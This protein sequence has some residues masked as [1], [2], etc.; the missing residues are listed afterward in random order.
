MTPHTPARYMH[1]HIQ[2]S[3]LRMTLTTFT[4]LEEA[5][6]M[7]CVLRVWT[8]QPSYRIHFNDLFSALQVN[9]DVKDIEILKRKAFCQA[10][11]TMSQLYI[12]L[13]LSFEMAT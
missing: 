7:Y 6:D 10:K 1:G 13:R 12:M 3:P 5:E 2:Y 11:P 4:P 9:N 8:F